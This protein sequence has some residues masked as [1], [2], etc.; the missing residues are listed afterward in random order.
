VFY[1]KGHKYSI[2][3]ISTYGAVFGNYNDMCFL[4]GK[5]YF[6][7]SDSTVYYSRIDNTVDT[8]VPSSFEADDYEVFQVVKKNDLNYLIAECKLISLYISI[9]MNQMT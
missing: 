2:G 6:H 5:W 3:C 4:D 7:N 9:F 1:S 8:R